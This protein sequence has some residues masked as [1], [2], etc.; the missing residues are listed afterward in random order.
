LGYA[1]IAGDHWNVRNRARALC[2][3]AGG[4]LRTSGEHVALLREDWTNSAATIDLIV[5]VTG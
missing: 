1:F 3:I 4:G 2:V 5:D